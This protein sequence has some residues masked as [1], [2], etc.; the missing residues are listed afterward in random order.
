MP[1]FLRLTVAASLFNPLFA[2]AL[3]QE[4][5]PETIVHSFK[6][7]QLATDY[8]AEGASIGDFD[9]DRK[10][11][12]VGGPYWYAGPDFTA[13]REIYPPVAQDR[14][15]YADNFFSFPYDFNGDGFDDVFVVGF[16]GTPGYWYE[17]PA[18]ESGGA[19]WKKHEV[20][21]WVG[22]E[23]PHFTNLVGDERPELICTRKGRIGYAKV[24]WESPTETWQFHTITLRG[25]AERFGHGLGVGDVNGDGRKDLLMPDG[26]YEQPPKRSP[27]WK[28]HEFRFTPRGGA[29]MFAYDVDGDGDNDVITGLWAH[30]HG[31]SWFENVPTGN[32][33]EPISFKEHRIMGTRPS[34]N[35]FGIVFS[36]LHSLD[37]ADVDGDGLKDIV[38]G[39]TYWS[40]HTREPG[41]HD[42]A[43]V[44]W[45][46]LSRKNGAV[47]FIPFEA[48]ADSGIG[49]QVVVGDVT[50]DGTA[51]IVT[52]NMKGTFVLTQSKLAVNRETWAVVQPKP[53][54]LAAN[55]QDPV[56]VLPNGEGGKPLNTDFET[57]DLTD[58]TETGTG[59]AF[60]GQ[61]AEGEIDQARK[62]GEGKLARP[63]GR[64]WIGG[65]EKSIDD[66]PVGT[67]T[68]KPFKLAHPFA[69]YRIGG[70][71]HVGIRMEI[72]LQ[73]GDRVIHT[74]HGR[75]SETMIPETVD[76]SV[77]HG[78]TAFL[79]L[80]DDHAGGFGHL[81]FDDF[82]LH[83]DPP[84]F[85]DAVTMMRTAK[86]PGIVTNKIFGPETKT[87]DY[88]HP[89]C[90]TQLDNGD[91]Y[92]AYY[93][94][95]G[96]YAMATVVYG[97]RKK[98][99]EPAWSDP[100]VIASN[101][102]RSLGNP[103]IWQA[104]G[105]IVW[106]FYVT[107][108][109][110]TWSTS[111]IKGKISRDGAKTWSES[112][113]LGW[114]EGTMVRNVPIVL[115]NGD[116]LLP[117]YHETGADTEFTGQDTTSRLLRL[118][119][120]TT[121][122]VESGVIRSDKGNLQP[123]V[124]QITEDRLIAFCRR[125]GDYEPTTKG[126]IVY[127]ESNDGG[128]TWSKGVDSKFP[129]PN[130]AIELKKLASGN[131]LLI[132]NDS[133]SGRTPLAAALSTDGGKTW[134]HKRNIA[135]GPGAFSYPTAVQTK[136]GKIHV[137]FT[138]DGRTTIRHA[139]FEEAWLLGDG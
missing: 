33:D 102:F 39:K 104:P 74:S 116:Y 115:K 21:D 2:A 4:S 12:I 118:K 42:G 69:S 73:D 11:D 56:G 48:D 22:N 26:W 65:F 122:W 90:F 20:F 10:P 129:N 54:A 34:E 41:W 29:Q 84:V 134:P 128:H 114:V 135:D 81:N 51:D 125:A 98:H 36:E 78:K 100:I 61:P 137:V 50:G 19:H 101:P 80:I 25:A 107:R 117:V 108:F 58:W 38:T 92:L 88:K 120:G 71:P 57:G 5:E 17:N 86:Q 52:A 109:G 63:Q 35:E 83:P 55:Q 37:L 46:K 7:R 67:L 94:G 62:W 3:A 13:R 87:G 82:R 136:D 30:G 75:N 126:W 111:R 59:D 60:H 14:N 91:L 70:G 113:V 132:Y 96:E 95:A 64:F 103:V 9:N 112:F 138:S 18:F 79:R 53:F 110:E 124:V 133:M 131:L 44:Y 97:T 24:N 121:E 139:V 72:V 106:L 15:R 47:Q 43:V 85:R 45:F 49:R 16:P 66:K 105:G 99:G 123:G 76:L 8:F 68:S 32:A 77:Y 23:S 6:K 28:F 119:K 93:G 31:L 89:S 1:H 130:S 27:I 127:S 40:H